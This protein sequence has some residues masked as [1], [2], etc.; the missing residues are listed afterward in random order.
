MNDLNSLF[1]SMS[2][3]FLRS[4]IFSGDLSV[5]PR[6]LSGEWATWPLFVTLSDEVLAVVDV[7]RLVRVVVR[8]VGE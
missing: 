5:L 7:L 2:W 4:F 3:A 1:V 6:E 8:V